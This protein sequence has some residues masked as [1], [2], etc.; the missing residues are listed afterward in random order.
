MRAELI[1]SDDE[2]EGFLLMLNRR[3]EELS[4]EGTK[5]HPFIFRTGWTFV[6][7]LFV[8]ERIK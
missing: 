7:F 1:K 6:A 3:L 8:E 2:P 4:S 5:V